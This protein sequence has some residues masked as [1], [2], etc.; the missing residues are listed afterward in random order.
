MSHVE[1]VEVEPCGLDDVVKLPDGRYRCT[2]CGC[3][4]REEWPD[5]IVSQGLVLPEVAA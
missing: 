1:S 5:A 2:V 3:F 4:M